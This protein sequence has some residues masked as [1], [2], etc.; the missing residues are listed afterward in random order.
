MQLRPAVFPA[1]AAAPRKSLLSKDIFLGVI[2][3]RYGTHS[4]PIHPIHPIRF[5][6]PPKI[7]S[8]HIF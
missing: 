1:I 5:P 3:V 2:R 7:H 6:N 4:L 8:Y